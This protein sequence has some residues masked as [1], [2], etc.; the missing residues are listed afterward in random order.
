LPQKEDSLA[1]AIGEANR[2]YTRRINFR[3]K[4]CGHLW[5]ECFSSFLMDEQHLLAA[6]RHVEMNPVAADLVKT[7]EDYRTSSLTGRAFCSYH[8]RKRL[9]GFSVMKARDANGFVDHL[10]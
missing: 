2:L 10:E 5:Q 4:W 1:R 7:P 6:A 8:L 3:E 9:I